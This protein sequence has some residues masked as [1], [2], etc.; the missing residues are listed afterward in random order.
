MFSNLFQKTTFDIRVTSFYRPDDLPVMQPCQSTEGRNSN[1]WPQHHPLDL[2]CS[3]AKQF[4]IFI[5]KLSQ[6]LERDISKN[7]Y[8]VMQ[9][10]V[11]GARC[12]HKWQSLTES[13]AGHWQKISGQCAKW[14]QDDSSTINTTT[15]KQRTFR[16]QVPHTHATYKSQILHYTIS[17]IHYYH[18]HYNY[19]HHHYFRLTAVFWGEPGSACSSWVLLYLFWNSTSGDYWNGFLWARWPS[20]YRTISVKTL[21]LISGLALSFLHP[22]SDSWQKRCCCCL[23]T[24]TEI[25]TIHC[26]KQNTKFNTKSSTSTT[27][28]PNFHLAALFS[29]VITGQVPETPG[30]YGKTSSFLSLSQQH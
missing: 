14:S 8:S 16:M 20:C 24:S 3:K 13:N 21:T 9:Q 23:Y 28:T 11:E 4:E 2:V 6:Q 22:Q 1:R 19:H 7:I 27:T 30:C 18:Y 25:S 17:T 5:L 12:K 29:V 15:P 10:P 26:S